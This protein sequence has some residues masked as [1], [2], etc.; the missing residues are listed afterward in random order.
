ME[1][2]TRVSANELREVWPI[3]SAPERVEGFLQLDSEEQGDFFLELTPRSQ[4]IVLEGLPEASRKIWIRLLEPDD[5]ADLLQEVEPER[6]ESL[7]A[8]LDAATRQEVVGL[9]AYAE[10]QAGGLMSTRFARLR[11]D[12]TV[13]EAIAYL[14]RQR[15]EQSETIYYSYV[16]DGDQRLIG[17]VSF[18]DLFAAEDAQRVRDVMVREI[19]SVA[20]DLDQ[21]SVSSIFARHDLM[22]LPVVD[23][24]GRIQ[25]IVTADD[26]V[27]V[28]QEE[29]TEDIQKLGGMEAL[30]RPYLQATLWEMIKKR[31]GWLSVLFLGEML[32][33]SA[34]GYFEDEIAR[35]V[36]LALFVPLIISSGGNSGS[37]AATLVIRAM[38]LG[39]VGLRDA[40][41][42][43]RRELATGVALGTLL[44]SLGILRILLW[45]KAFHLYGPHYIRVALTV[46]LSLVG[47]VI[48]GTL[49][50]A[51]LPFVIRRLGFDPA[52]ASAPFV[53]TLVDVSGLVIYFSV[54]RI[55]LAGAML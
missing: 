9:M 19:I 16:V 39:Q 54:A 8:L 3:L 52:S 24:Q 41:R 53:A 22:A 37:Q 20:D 17:V 45:E 14:R 43:I 31:G 49:S 51:L 32:T 18:R 25:G 33:A 2:A 6:Q 48:W 27:D 34:M 11:P 36:V 13:K 15:R 26:I 12:M 7:L 42:V 50:G 55:F 10:D 21:E 1:A 38:A 4:S 23:K 46:G 28:V 30:D 35:A 29:A 47:V 5:V 44:A 40:W